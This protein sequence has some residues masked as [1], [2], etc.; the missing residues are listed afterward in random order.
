MTIDTAVEFVR[1]HARAVLAT[2]RAN[3]APQLSPI[4]VGVDDAGRLEVSSRETAYKV[5]NLRRDPSASL[6][7][8]ADQFFGPWVQID[9]EAVIVSLPEAMEPLVAYY[10]RLSGDHPNWDEYRAAMESERRVLIQITPTRAG[11]Q[12][13][14]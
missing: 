9:G 2:N 11:P 10:R 13:S 5:R 12:H 7:V 4:L 3:G 6:C 8:F 1:T 14:G